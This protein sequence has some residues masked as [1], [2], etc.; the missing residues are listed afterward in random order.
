MSSR[1]GLTSGI[2]VST[3]VHQE[4]L[5][6]A[7]LRDMKAL[8][9]GRGAYFVPDVVWHCRLHDD[10]TKQTNLGWFHHCKTSTDNLLLIT[11][12]QGKPFSP[13]SLGTALRLPSCWALG[14]P[15]QASNYRTLM[16]PASSYPGPWGETVLRL[17]E[18]NWGFRQEVQTFSETMSH[19]GWAWTF[20][21]LYDHM[22]SP[23]G[24]DYEPEVGRF[25]PCRSSG[26][27]LFSDWRSFPSRLET[28]WW[29]EPRWRCGVGGKIG[30]HALEGRQPE[31]FTCT[32]Y[33]E[34]ID[35]YTLN[36][37]FSACLIKNRQRFPK[38]RYNFC[39]NLPL[40]LLEKTIL[41]Q[42]R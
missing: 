9:P 40:I 4:A 16:F 24:R 13:P 23:P 27:S 5:V 29:G 12:S 32:W 14:C 41:K 8:H 19:C 17:E 21:V 15:E 38:C 7:V 3:T 39:N 28:A 33:K 36:L 2:A 25:W 10:R 11:C 30:R 6:I 35:M 20:W 31:S 22:F 18:V 42:D 26:Q 34:E 37:T 1:F